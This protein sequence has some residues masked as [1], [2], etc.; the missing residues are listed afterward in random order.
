[1]GLRG[2]WCGIKALP[3]NEPPLPQTRVDLLSR[4]QPAWSGIDEAATGL[5][6]PACAG[7]SLGRGSADHE[8]RPRLRGGG[9]WFRIRH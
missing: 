6:A 3:F 4:S 5:A 8:G 7:G 2:A 9:L 1:M